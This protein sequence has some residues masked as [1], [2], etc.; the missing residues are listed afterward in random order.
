MP[1]IYDTFLYFQQTVMKKKNKPR[2]ITQDDIPDEDSFDFL[3]DDDLENEDEFQSEI[4]DS[5]NVTSYQNGNGFHHL[6]IR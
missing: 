4:H 1:K 6:I 3:D 5:N 2:K